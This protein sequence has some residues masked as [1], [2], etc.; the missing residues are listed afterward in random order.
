MKTIDR[1]YILVLVTAASLLC[2]C[3]TPISFGSRVNTD[4]PVIKN[5]PGGNQPGSYLSGDTNIILL[6]V[7]QDFGLSSVFMTVWFSDR[8]DNKKQKILPAYL[9]GS[10]LWEVN[11]DTTGMADGSIR[12]QVTAVDKDGKMTITTDIIYVVKNTPPQIELTLPKVKGGGFD[13]PNL[14]KILADAPLYQGNDILGIASDLFGIEGGYPEILIWP[15][16]YANTDNNG[17]VPESDPKWGRWRTVVDEN[18]R[19]LGIAGLNAAQFRWPMMEFIEDGSTWRLPKDEELLDP[20]KTKDL[21]VGIYRVKFRVMDKFGTV[22]TYPNRLDNGFHLPQDDEALN[23]YMEI[24]LVAAKNPS[25][26]WYAFPQYYNGAGN[27]TATVNISTPNDSIST[28]RVI[29]GSS[30]EAV[31]TYADNS[32]VKQAT[33]NSWEITITPEV[34]REM[35]G[36]ADGKKMSGDWILHLEAVDNLGNRTATSRQFIIDDIDPVLEFIEPVELNKTGT[37][38]H[39]PPRLTSTVTIRGAAIDNQRVT[40]LYY[41]L[42]RTETG[43]ALGGAWNDRT[44][45]TDSGLNDSPRNDHKGLNAKWSGS[46]SSWSWRFDDIA[47]VCKGANAAYYAEEY[48]SAGNLWLLPMKFKVVDAAGNV[49]IY[50]AEIIVDPEADR[51][52]VSISSHNERQIVGGMVRLSGFAADNEWINNVEIRVTAQ[53]D[54][55]CNTG[56]PPNQLMTGG[57]FVPANIVGNKSAAVNWYFNINENGELDP[58]KGGT[59]VVLL[60]VR[61]WDASMYAQN[62]PKNSGVTQLYL[63]FD[64]SAPVIEDV[65]VIFGRPDDIGTAAEEALSPGTTVKEFAVLMARV[66]DDSGITSIKLRGKGEAR[67]EEYIDRGNK[68]NA[69]PW[70]AAPRELRAGNYITAG[71]KYWIKESLGSDFGAFQADGYKSNGKD[72]TFIAVKGGYFSGGS[73]LVEANAADGMTQFFEY[74]V[75]IP[76]N[77]NA[78]PSDS[79]SLCGGLYYNSAGIY[80]AD[81]QIVDN[82]NPMPF[83]TLDTFSLCIDN[84]YPMASFSGD[85]NA[86]GNYQLFGRAWDTGSSGIGVQ[87]LDKVVVYFSRNG[88]L[89]SLLNGEDAANSSGG[90][91][92]SVSGQMAKTGRTG[93]GNSVIN[94]GTLT[95][96]PFFPNV[97]LQDGSCATND[98]GIVIDSSQA[99]PYS[100]RFTGPSADRD[101]QVTFPSANLGDGPLAVHYVVFDTADNATH[102]SRDIYVANNRPIITSISLGTDIDGYNGVRPDEYED[103]PSAAFPEI[104]TGAEL[105]TNFRVRN[106]QFRVNLNTAGGN[107]GRRYRVS[108]VERNQAEVSITGIVKGEVYSIADT[109]SGIR[110]INY[111]VFGNPSAGTVFVATQS[112]SELAAMGMAGGTGGKVHTYKYMGDRDKTIRETNSSGSD[113]LLAFTPDSFSGSGRIEDSA[114]DTINGTATPRFDR[115]FL[116]KVYDTAFPDPASPDKA[117]EENQLSHAALV[118]IAVDNNDV[119]APVIFVDPFYWNSATDN[120]LYGNSG[121]NGHIELEAYLPLK[122]TG[123]SAVDDL[124]PKVS[125]RVSFRGTASDNNI[126]DSIKFSITNFR[127]PGAMGAIIT[128]GTFSG[129]IWI[130]NSGSEEDFDMNGW[131][132]SAAGIPNQAG[133]TADWQLD[134]DSS[135]IDGICGADNVLTVIAGDR[136]A[137]SSSPGSFLQTGKNTRTAHYRFDVAPYITEVETGLSG[138]YISNPSAFSRSALGAYPVREGE[139]IRI[140]GFNFSGES[141]IA[142]V[143]GRELDG[144]GAA[145]SQA[146]GAPYITAIIDE[147]W[148][149]ADKNTIVSG[150][151]TAEV[152]GIPSINNDNDDDAPYNREPNGLNNNILTDNRRLYV[153][154]TGFLLN[155]RMIQSPFMR[156]APDSTRYMSYGIYDGY[157][158]FFVRKNNDPAAHTPAN[159]VEYWENRYLNTT[160]AFDEYGDWYA[161]ASNMTAVNYPHFTF[162]ARAP[163]SGNNGNIGSNKRIIMRTAYAA[164]QFDADRARIPRIFA[165]NTDG[166]K[167]S[168]ARATRIFMSYYDNGSGDNPVLFHYGTVGNNNNF[169]GNLQNN[170][171]AFTRHPQAQVVANNST[172]Y[173]GSVY[174]AVGALSNGLPVIAWYDRYNQNLMFSH[175]GGGDTAPLNGVPLGTVYNGLASGLTPSDTNTECVYYAADHKLASGTGSANKYLVIGA[176]FSDPAPARYFA[177]RIDGNRF[178]FDAASSGTAISQNTGLNL[179]ADVTVSRPWSAA[180]GAQDHEGSNGSGTAG[181]TYWYTLPAEHDLKQ[182]DRV[183]IS[184]GTTL[185]NHILSQ[186]YVRAV[187]GNN[188]KFSSL[189]TDENGYFLKQAGNASNYN[190][191]VY[192]L[193]SSCSFRA[194]GSVERYYSPYGN[195][196][197]GNTVTV[198]GAEYIVADR[199][200]GNNTNNFKLA[201]I[202][203]GEIVSSLGNSP[204]MYTSG[205]NIVT[206]ETGAPGTPGTWQGNAV[207]VAGFAGTHVDLAVDG[208]DNVHLAYY[209]VRN[210]GLHYAYIP[211]LGGR[212]TTAK[213]D[214]N[215][216]QKARVD[217][218][219][220]AGTKLTISVRREGNLPNGRAKYVPYISYFHASFAETRNAIRVAWRRDFSRNDFNGTDSNDRFTGAWEV[221]TVPVE[222]VPLSEEFICHGVPAAAAWIL[223]GG[224]S[225]LHYNKSMN[226]TMLVGYMTTDWYEGAVLKDE[227]W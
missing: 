124:D 199:W 161:A 131:K 213:P 139:T 119:T 214:T 104:I 132:F 64:L 86:L 166:S 223:P 52:V 140:R 94:E 189:N 158:R 192:L 116:I 21:P 142:R 31:F 107:G 44:G 24:N 53:S 63:V 105:A 11:I 68:Q 198:N 173:R 80:S 73:V 130:S 143:G 48:G 96:L 138:A 45:W 195:L 38:A 220:S 171:A 19:P 37:P 222:T 197:T 41:A 16:D 162:Y 51:P 172:A 148:R 102:Y 4:V 99:G 112:H 91:A 9:N 81:I 200:T 78:P 57:G 164:N 27:F 205:G 201:N 95:E 126:I 190:V 110:W 165:Q 134:F 32:F 89:V 88:K 111:G 121:D 147:R 176:S 14:N 210:G 194:R 34:M 218:Y 83:I 212:T 76:L 120:S 36:V 42:G 227:L 55:D 87:G 128:A 3:D 54:K 39:T 115:S 209:D 40:A 203:T 75:Y 25:I 175:G 103:F 106:S 144:V 92:P 155:Q 7:R 196:V 82:T 23:R 170:N 160:V 85:L 217:T 66:R 17:I 108:W 216:V 118:K 163:A 71:K 47:D 90:P 59:R 49:S 146:A 151:L 58:P 206:T 100:P 77:T 30:E 74:T 67:Y 145:A 56:N 43:A 179:G 150:W 177:R 152:N 123:V 15:A 20:E 149:P 178:I 28:V 22:N 137:N 129:G 26:K 211:A 157:G 183:Y 72:T 202:D 97:R 153:W 114:K 46:L 127:F 93:S 191:S 98:Y 1:Y 70:I 169:H 154:N 33:G 159:Q 182:G 2:A 207:K 174:T 133:H 167:G 117:A 193:N 221:L 79:E 122:P 180:Q 29:A 50:S 186:Y 62:V 18:Y 8:S 187:S 135:F 156:V 65:K 188:V 5:A 84:Y 109:G 12:A 6:D 69:R 60:E 13:V 101:W 181:R 141:T 136:A 204:V 219:L 113:A 184:T 208:D 225:T 35:L 125:G 185:A 61:A 215:N 224:A 226:K 168:D 10:G